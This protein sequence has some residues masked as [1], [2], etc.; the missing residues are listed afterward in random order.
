M[1]ETALLSV[2]DAPTD[3]GGVCDYPVEARRD[4]VCL[5]VAYCEH[6]TDAGDI[7]EGALSLRMKDTTLT[8]WDRQHLAGTMAMLLDL[9]M[10]ANYV[11]QPRL[12]A[13]V[14]ERL[15][16]DIST[17]FQQELRDVLGV[18]AEPTSEELA[19]IWRDNRHLASGV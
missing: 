17:T 14:A 2:T 7:N 11:E 9:Y 10:L 18:A 3:A 16:R 6:H 1:C 15:A 5:L 4:S 13:A 12:Q 8:A 19:R